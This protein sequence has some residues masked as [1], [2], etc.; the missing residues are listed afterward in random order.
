MSNLMENAQS[1][2][3][4]R[5]KSLKY[6]FAIVLISLISCNKTIPSGFWLNYRSDLI[7]LKNIDHGPYGG[8]TSIIWNR[9][10]KIKSSEV[11]GYANKNGWK[12]VDSLNSESIKDSDY[13]N[14]ILIENALPILK[15][16]DLSI[17]RFKTGWIAVKPGN[18]SDTEINGFII[19]NHK[20]IN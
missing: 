6:L 16:K 7:A 15:E 19:L 2:N 12:L 14:Q 4:T 10:E 18:E 13:S 1:K 17:Y 5:M 3:T 9:I 20:K 8:E 11:I